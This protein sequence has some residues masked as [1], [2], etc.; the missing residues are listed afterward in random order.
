MKF[1]FISI[2]IKRLVLQSVC[3]FLKTN[4][5]F[6]HTPAF[7]GILNSEMKGAPK[8]AANRAPTG[9]SIEPHPFYRGKMILLRQF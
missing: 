7:K 1:W 9:A 4:V 8:K 6:C 5:K 3:V 2:P